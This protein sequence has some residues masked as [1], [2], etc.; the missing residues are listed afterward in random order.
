MRRT[1]RERRDPRSSRMH[2]LAPLWLAAALAT[3]QT[4][5]VPPPNKIPDDLQRLAA[6]V[7]KA[8][9]PDGP[10]ARVTSLEAAMQLHVKAKNQEQGQVDITLR[11][12]EWRAPDAKKPRPL[13]RYEVVDQ[14]TPI[15]RGNDGSGPWQLVR[16]EARDMFSADMQQDLA[17]FEKHTNL[18]KQLL[19]FLAP[20]DVLRSL[21]KPGGVGEEKLAVTIEKDVDCRTVSG[22]LP[23]F[24]LLQQ[25]GEDAPVALK[26]WVEKSTNQLIAVDIWPLRDGKKD[27]TRG[28]RVLLGSRRVRGG[29]LVPLRLEHLY[30]LPDGSLSL[31]S[32][33]DLTSLELGPALTVE[34]FD[35]TRRR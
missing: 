11:Y 33:A 13:L 7:E 10:Q 4:P 3:A 22:E 24:P 14:G 6:D 15:V 20:G 5:A 27:E 8:H 19:R 31:Q 16:G 32:Q 17:Q 1:D 30:R 34:E 21:Q 18:V 23:A 25:A 9:W 12:L 35:R 26:V 29:F 2:K 28:E